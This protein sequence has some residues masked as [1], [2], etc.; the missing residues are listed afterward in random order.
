[1]SVGINLNFVF[2][3]RLKK[4]SKRQDYRLG[5]K[6]TPKGG[7]AGGRGDSGVSIVDGFTLDVCNH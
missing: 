2:I 5:S 6:H 7:T 4:F 1:M 3:F